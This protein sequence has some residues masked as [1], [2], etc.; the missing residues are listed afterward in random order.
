MVASQEEV[1]DASFP[2]DNLIELF[3]KH[4]NEPE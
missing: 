2:Y 4:G 1:P 3:R